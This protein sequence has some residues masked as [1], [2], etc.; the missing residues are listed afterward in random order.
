M[1]KV[2]KDR[3]LSPAEWWDSTKFHLDMATWRCYKRETTEAN[4]IRAVGKSAIPGATRSGK[5]PIAK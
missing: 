4:G 2:D 5:E 1:D 3:P